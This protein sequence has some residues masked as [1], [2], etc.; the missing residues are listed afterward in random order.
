M[1]NKLGSLYLLQ[2]IDLEVDELNMLRGDIPEMVHELERKIE[3][4]ELRNTA[5]E[6]ELQADLAMKDA[7]ERESREL[8]EGID[9]HK[10]QLLQVRNNREYDALTNE[11]DVSEATIRSN[12]EYVEQLSVESAGI[13]EKQ[14]ELAHQMEEHQAELEQY[15]KQLEEVMATTKKDEEKFLTMRAEAVKF[16][17]AE[18]LEMYNRIR[19]AKNGKAVVVVKNKMSCSGCNNVIPPQLRLEIKKN[20]KLHICEHCGRILVSELIAHETKIT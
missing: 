7:K 15:T 6:N 8:Q 19:A 17:D 11:I 5:Y 2:L 12:E 13:R 20:N 18:H 14:E 10:A 4:L 1:K 3:D 16:V 9:R